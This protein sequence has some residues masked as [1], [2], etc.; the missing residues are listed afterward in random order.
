MKEIHLTQD[1]VAFVD[2]EDFEGLS[3]YKWAYN[4]GYVVR[5]NRVSD[6][7]YK[8]G[9]L[10]L[11]HRQIMGFPKDKQVYHINHIRSDNQK[12]NLRICSRTENMRNRLVQSNKTKTK[13]KGVSYHKA[14]GKWGLVFQKKWIGYFETDLEGA[15]EYDKLARENYGEFASLNFPEL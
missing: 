10:V 15:K 7:E 13:Y 6:L 11:M 2:D 4:K 14:S 9:G 5:A 3:K 1:K 8:D 12:K